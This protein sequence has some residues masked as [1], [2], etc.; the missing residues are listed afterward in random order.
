MS[1]ILLL[2]LWL[3]LALVAVRDV[4]AGGGWHAAAIA[5]CI[6]LAGSLGWAWRSQRQWPSLLAV[7]ALAGMPTL[8]GW[9]A[10]PDWRAIGEVDALAM[11]SVVFTAQ[12]WRLVAWAAA[13]MMLGDAS[14][15]WLD[16][17]IT[18][19]PGVRAL[20]AAWAVWLHQASALGVFTAGFCWFAH[21]LARAEAGHRAAIAATAQASLRE[22]ADLRLV[23]EAATDLAAHAAEDRMAREFESEIGGLIS[24]AA[25]AAGKV[26]RAASEICNITAA[27][28]QRTVAITEATQ[29]TWTS[30]Q[31]VAEAVETLAGSI[32]RVTQ[33][34]RGVS[35]A[36]FRAMD[37]AS[38]NN[39]TVQNL[40]DAAQRIGI[41]IRAI[42]KIAT[43]THMLALNATIEATRAGAAGL[44]FGVVASEVKDLARQT[45]RATADIEGE[46]TAIRTEMNKAM[47]AIDGMA[48]VVAELGGVTVSVAAAM[49]EQTDIAR[50]ITENA[51]RA[52]AGTATVRDNLQA[53]MSE[54]SRGD[55][56]AQEGA[57]DATVLAETCGA[58]QQAVR[59]FVETLL[60]A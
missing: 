26:R 47:A 50:Q 34:V 29:E 22:E 59:S 30:A 43:Q 16:T 37:E 46:V 60:A 32:D 49:E 24:E 45:A 19:H 11:L 57:R 31:T 25:L 51:L 36:S 4:L 28:S 7:T 14:V 53:L 12:D 58:V 38:S 18:L 52:A 21:V 33:E 41:I 54:T 5:A 56:A 55:V 15:T 39:E 40:S 42:N 1:A 17:R 48:G 13:L 8:V 9:H 27:T 35:E 44:G 10:A 2:A 6:A 3:Q 20:P 23:S